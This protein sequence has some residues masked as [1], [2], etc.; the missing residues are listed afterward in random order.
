M[1]SHN[2]WFVNFYSPQCGHCH[3][4]A[5]T[6]RRV[7]RMLNGI[8]RIGAVNCQDDFAIC[9]QQNIRSVKREII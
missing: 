7:A 3:E 2:Y 5:P 6:W 8:V 1:H 9:Q 4:L